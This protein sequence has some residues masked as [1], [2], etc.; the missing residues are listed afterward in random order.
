M[1]KT[2]RQGRVDKV[3]ERLSIKNGESSIGSRRKLRRYVLPHH[4]APYRR[5]GEVVRVSVKESGSRVK[6]WG[7]QIGS[8]GIGPG[9]PFQRKRKPGGLAHVVPR[10]RRD[11]AK[12]QGGRYVWGQH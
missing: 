10:D 6:K 12:K 5:W 9:A 1:R 8:K 7:G 3:W 2:C 4:D 11:Q